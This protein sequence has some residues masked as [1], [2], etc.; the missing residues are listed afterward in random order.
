MSRRNRLKPVRVRRIVL[1]TVLISEVLA[2]AALGVVRVQQ[3]RRAGRLLGCTELKAGQFEVAL[4]SSA[5]RLDRYYGSMQGPADKLAGI[6]VFRD[7]S[8]DTTVWMTGA[9]TRIVAADSLAP[10]SPEY[11]CHANLTLSPEQGTPLEHNRGFGDKTHLDWR[12]FTLVPGRMSIRLPEGFGIPIRNRTM[13]DL[14]T[15]SLN[16]NPGPIARDVRMKTRLFVHA[17][18]TPLRPLFRRAL[19]VYQ[20]HQT[21]PGADSNTPSPGHEGEACALSVMEDQQGETPSR[22]IRIRPTPD[23]PTHPGASC[24]V[25]NASAGGIL[26]QFGPDHTVHWMVPPGRHRYRSDVSRQLQLPFDTTVHYAT[27]HLHPSGVSL[28]LIDLETSETLFHITGRGFPNRTGVAHMSEYSSATGVPL[29]RDGRYELIAEYDNRTDAPIDAMGI[30]YL[31]A[32][33]NDFP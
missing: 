5:Y 32:T 33:E 17:G 22:F 3:H 27:G 28:T 16:Q 12:L 26:P 31:Y 4:L 8:P 15:M 11:F 13:L 29:H 2:A 18:D 7:A 6:Q 20:Q 1:W 30:L 24:C 23:D 14:F 25:P 19:Y 9:D 21:G 10:I